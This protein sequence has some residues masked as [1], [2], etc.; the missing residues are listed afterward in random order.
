[1]E[2]APP[3]TDV[4]QQ[5][6]AEGGTC[7]FSGVMTVAFGANGSYNYATLNGG[8]ACSVAVFGDP[9]AG[10]GKSC[11]VQDLPRGA[12]DVTAGGEDRN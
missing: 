11:C 2:T 10:T 7:S 6:A 1:V 5:C 3:A 4:W 12:G 8:T 9:A